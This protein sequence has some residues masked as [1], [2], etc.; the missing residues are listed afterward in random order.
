MGLNGI[1]E[2]DVD[3]VERLILETLS[4]IADGNQ[5]VNELGFDEERI[6]SVLHQIELSQRHVTSNFGINL[7]YSLNSYWMHGSDPEVVLQLSEQIGKLKEDLVT[8]KSI[9]KDLIRKYFLQNSH[10]VT[11]IMKPDDKY[12]EQQEKHEREMLEKISASLSEEDKEH[13]KMKA[14]ALK[15]RQEA[16]QDVSCLPSLQISDIPRSI[17][18]PMQWTIK[19]IHHLRPSSGEP[20]PNRTFVQNLDD[21]GVA[22]YYGA[23]PTNGVTYFRGMISLSS[24]PRELA[25]YVPLFCSTLTK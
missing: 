12:M 14:A 21:S 25:P 1:K 3:K 6:D 2:A 20:A 4:E 23:Q 13:I 22:L 24:I 19:N 9:F 8:N 11:L 18:E 10:R 5:N 16:E 7:C 15:Q 17:P